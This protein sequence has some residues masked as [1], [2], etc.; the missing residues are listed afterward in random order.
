L[1]SVAAGDVELLVATDDKRIVDHAALA[2]CRA[3]LT[4]QAITSGSGRALAAAATLA[5]PPRFVV[6]L[7]GDA[8]YVPASAVR[9]VL[10]ELRRSQAAC[11]TPVVQ[12]N[13]QALDRLRENKRTTP[14]SGTTCLRASDGRALWF[15]KA[16]L[17][18]IRNEERHRLASPVSPVHQHLGLYGYTLE[19]LAAFEALPPSL[20]EECEG[21]EQL[22]LLEHGIP[23]QT[24]VIDASPALGS[25]I[26]TPEDA[27]RAQ[28]QLL[29]SEPAAS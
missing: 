10:T 5:S 13:W 6:N 16:V 12:L 18:V 25:G 11:V 2:G 4:D 14:F 24:V 20:Y 22:R 3:V 15:S 23:I 26:D 28:R 27:E 7:Q 9:A 21:L 29:A 19:T 8:L 1:S 17:P